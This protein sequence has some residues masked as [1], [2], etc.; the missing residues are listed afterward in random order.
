[1]TSNTVSEEGIAKIN[2]TSTL[3]LRKRGD[4]AVTV[5]EQIGL[6]HD[7]EKKCMK[8]MMQIVNFA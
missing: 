5:R 8:Q 6:L 2:A 3:V 1:M 7:I 4:S